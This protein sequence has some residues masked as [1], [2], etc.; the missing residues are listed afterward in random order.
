[1]RSRNVATKNSKKRRHQNRNNRD[2]KLRLRGRHNRNNIPSRNNI[3]N[4][5]L[6]NTRNLC[7]IRSPH[8]TNS[9]HLKG[10]SKGRKLRPQNRRSNNNISKSRLSVRSRRNSSRDSRLSKRSVRNHNNASSVQRSNFRPRNKAELRITEIL[11][12]RGA[13][14]ADS[15]TPTVEFR[16]I[17][18]APILEA[19][20]FSA[21]TSNLL[22]ADIRVSSTADSGL[23]CMT[24]GRM[25]G[26]T[27]T[28][29]TWISRTV[30]TICMT[31]SVPE[32][33][34]ELT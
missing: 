18:S 6:S 26:M 15:R 30:T 34:C 12:Q 1:V 29:F 25:D 7:N 16:M 5:R 23:E 31:A 22:S 33:V 19:I 14:P 11:P 32:R 4:R 24:P 3:R 10:H 17:V 27:R 13:N 21:F 8:S 28:T 9:R 2:S 20:T